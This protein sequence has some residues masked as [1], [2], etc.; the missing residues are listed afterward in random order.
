V[1]ILLI[2]SKNELELAHSG[3]RRRGGYS[4]R[5]TEMQAIKKQ[6]WLAALKE[7]LVGTRGFE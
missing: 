1:V 4:A 5:V 2:H 6:L 3:V 7:V